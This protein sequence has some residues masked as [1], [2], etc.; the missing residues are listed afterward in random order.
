MPQTIAKYSSVLLQNERFLSI[1]RLNPF[2]DEDVGSAIRLI[3]P[4]SAP[5]SI[6][7]RFEPAGLRAGHKF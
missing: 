7:F 6:P 2:R 5:L 4:I 1:Y 3:R